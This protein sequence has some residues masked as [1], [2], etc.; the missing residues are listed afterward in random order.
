MVTAFKLLILVFLTGCSTL[1]PNGYNQRVWIIKG[2][3][4][5]ERGILT[6]DCS[7]F[8]NYKIILDDKR[9]ICAKI[10]DMERI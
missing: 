6:G 3:Y 7:G 5:G 10:W 2:L 9:I 1:T 4:R 8:E